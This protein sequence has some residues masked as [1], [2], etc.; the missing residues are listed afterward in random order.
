MKEQNKRPGLKRSGVSLHIAVKAALPKRDCDSLLISINVYILS[1]WEVTGCKPL[2]KFFLPFAVSV[3]QNQILHQLV[4]RDFF[5]LTISLVVRHPSTAYRQPK[6]HC[7]RVMGTYL[8]RRCE[9]ESGV[10]VPPRTQVASSRLGS[11]ARMC[12]LIR[13]ECHGVRNR[14]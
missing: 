2:L 6:S 11:R 10:S 4:V 13:M 3:H 1:L 12:V 5:Q 7:R 8:F 14:P 9:L